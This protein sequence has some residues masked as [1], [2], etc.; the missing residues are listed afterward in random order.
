MKKCIVLMS[1]LLLMI[2]NL[3]S[4][5]K[6]TDSD[7]KPVDNNGA[8]TQQ[9]APEGDTQSVTPDTTTPEKTETTE[10]AAPTDTTGGEAPKAAP[11]MVALN[12]E[13]PNAVFRGTPTNLQVPNLE[14]PL[15]RPRD[16]FYAPEGTVLVSKG[17]P[18]IA[19]DP[20]FGELSLITDGDKEAADGCY[21]VLGPM[22]QEIVIDLE[23]MYEIYAIVVWHFH[24]QPSV[25]YDVIAQIG[26][27]PD[28]ITSKIV[29][30]NDIDNS[31]QMGVGTDMHYIETSE[32]KLIDAKGTKGRYVK[33]VSGGNNANDLN[34]YIEV[35]VWGKPVE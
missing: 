25:Y 24:Q 15:G 29:F 27:D 11:G 33:M 2:L 18:V 8:G 13:L 17:K 14:K 6:S 34:H 22:K 32:G 19:E 30:N 31:A 12:I 26:E 35:E 20:I 7:T 16:P 5:K 23:A 10:Q 28:F 9:K 3:T 4:C 1:I 21:V